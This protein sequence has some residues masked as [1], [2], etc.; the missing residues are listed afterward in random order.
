[1]SKYSEDLRKSLDITHFEG[2]VLE[3]GELTSA[4]EQT[5]AEMQRISREY[6]A[7]M[8]M[9][10]LEE[11]EDQRILQK[12]MAGGVMQDILYQLTRIADALERNNI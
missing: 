3:P 5:R 10:T 7:D 6:T 1:M 2:G 4:Q 9:H 12:E 8:A 11:L